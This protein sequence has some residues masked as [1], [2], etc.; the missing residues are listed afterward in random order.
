MY[1]ILV[2]IILLVA[3]GFIFLEQNVFGAKPAGKRL[4]LI[5]K[6]KNYK[7]G[8]FRNE[9]HTPSL[10][11]GYSYLGIFYDFFFREKPDLQPL[12]SIPSITT[13]LRSLPREANLLVWFGHSS[14]LLQLE[15]KTILVDPVLSGYA[16]PF[17][18]MNKAFIG[19]DKYKVA[20]L[21]EI[22]YLLI[23]HDHYDHL[24]FETVKKL[25]GRVG[26]VI[27]PLG[28]GAH[29]EKWGYE[30]SQLI[31]KDWG[32]KVVLDSQIILYFTPARHFS[33]RSLYSNNTL[34]TSFVLETPSKKIFVG[35]DSGYDSHFAVIG[36]IFGGFDLA[37]LENGQYNEAWRYIHTLPDE[38]LK[39]GRDLKAKRIF[40]VHSG[41]FNLGGHAWFE[42]L[43]KITEL[44][45]QA[46]Q[47]LITPMIGEVVD[48]DNEKQMFQNWWESDDF[49]IE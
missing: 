9:S 21:P 1:F 42:P 12:D 25:K 35:G 32:A 38:V 28:V 30:S 43:A 16:S 44:N 40:P 46:N 20:D 6:S 3:G 34:W 37:I 33:G 15:G 7:N 26:K 24:D 17:K 49:D 19:S 29:F 36:K 41:K 22:D 48:L 14:Y 4:E 10:V 11:E 2:A 8:K 27:C 31:E 13:Y 45:K 5:R 47:Q 18:S 39:A 23:T